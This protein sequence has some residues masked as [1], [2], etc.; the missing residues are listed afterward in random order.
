MTI[1]NTDRNTTKD[2]CGNPIFGITKPLF[3][4]LLCA[5]GNLGFAEIHLL[6][7]FK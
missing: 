7:F 2:N 5:D 3:S 4:S 6:P 1:Q